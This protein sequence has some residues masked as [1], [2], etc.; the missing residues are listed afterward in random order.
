MRKGKWRK[1][2]K[3]FI[4]IILIDILKEIQMTH[5]IKREI[6]YQFC[7]NV[8][9]KAG[10]SEEDAS[11]IADSLIFANLRGIDSHGIMRFPFY[12]KRAEVGGTNCKPNI[13]SIKEGI[14]TALLDGD[15]GM[16]QVIGVHAAQLA[17]QKARNTGVATVGVKGSSHYGAAS[18]YSVLISR[19][20][21]IGFSMT[22]NTQ[23]MAAWGGANKVIGN[24]PIS[25]AVPYK[26][27]MP[28]VLDISMSTVAGGKVRLAAKNKERIPK[29]WI[30]DKNGEFSDDP[31]A[32]AEGG[33]LLPF[34]GHKGYGL[35]VIIEILSA[36]LT[37]GGLLGQVPMW[38]K[39]FEEPLNIGHMFGAINI[40]NFIEYDLFLERLEYTVEQLKNSTVA[41]GF[42]K[43][44]IPGEIEYE[45][46][47]VRKKD[48]IQISE[49]IYADLKK[50]SD[51]YQ[52]P[53]DISGKI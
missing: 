24:N 4:R 20:R 17:I 7:K 49:E 15:N 32:L 3:Y 12:L 47:K 1:F 22:G 50:I 2:K 37:G 23:V 16:G 36:V 38:I 18:Y 19:Q 8:L 53:L 26:E 41:K 52:V 34:G 39:D 9:S 28:I 29:D 33:A 43:I 48:G 6:L 11:T 5:K 30:V 27:D 35:A 44:Y 14:S 10:C 46:E 31:N 51:S 21:M 25:V 42:S 40:E 45:K 13:T